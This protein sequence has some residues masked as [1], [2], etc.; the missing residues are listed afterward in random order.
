MAL[1]PWS[2]VVPYVRQDSPTGGLRVVLIWPPKF[3]NI[4]VALTLL[5]IKTPGDHQLILIQQLTRFEII[6]LVKYYICLGYLWSICSILII[7]N[8]VLAP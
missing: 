7:C 3:P 8:Y 6:V 2:T 5:E 1:P 4:V